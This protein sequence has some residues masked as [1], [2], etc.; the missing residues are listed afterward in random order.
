MA[1]ICEDSGYTG[2]S[3]RKEAQAGILPS[4]G[5]SLD[6]PGTNESGQPPMVHHLYALTQRISMPHADSYFSSM[7]TYQSPLRHHRRN[8]S[9]HREV[10]VR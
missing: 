10:K 9:Y 7:P 6:V 1:G 3:N 8:A 4:D 2:D 5:I